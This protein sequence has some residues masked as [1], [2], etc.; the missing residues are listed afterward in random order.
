MYQQLC[1]GLLA[2]ASVTCTIAYAQQ[3]PGTTGSRLGSRAARNAVISFH[4][5]RQVKE[6]ERLLHEDRDAEA[7]ELART[8]AESFELSVPIGES[9]L[10][11]DRYFA[12]N[13]L[14]VVQTKVGDSDAAILACSD[15][16]ALFPNRW[17]ALNNRGTA[18][19]VSQR[20]GLALA[21]YRR[22]L[23]VAPDDSAVIETIQH[24]ISLCEEQLTE[25]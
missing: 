6:I 14:C 11:S 12:L 9:N 24:N 2:I 16:I 13:A 5:P 20:Y 22:A 25:A 21:D 3:Q 17:T 15:A 23:E 7:L 19:Y 18:Y 8:Y 1:A 4:S 10:E